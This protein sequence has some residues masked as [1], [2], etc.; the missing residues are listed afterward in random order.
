MNAKQ[1]RDNCENVPIEMYSKYYKDI[2]KQIDNLL[3]SHSM[4]GYSYMRINLYDFN[5]LVLA[6]YSVLSYFVNMF[7]QDYKNEGFK[8]AKIM[9]NILEI[10]WSE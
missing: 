1:L 7:I 8:V 4:K 9:S 5:P 3:V 10:S 2:K 6:S